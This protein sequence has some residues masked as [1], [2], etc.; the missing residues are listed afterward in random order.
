LVG[1]TVTAQSLLGGHS[2]DGQSLFHR[3]GWEQIDE[4]V[5]YLE[6][7][8]GASVHVTDDDILITGFHPA[9]CT[10]LVKG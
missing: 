9:S 1:L 8:E 6:D 10:L 4:I 7:I 2:P 3:F 5:S